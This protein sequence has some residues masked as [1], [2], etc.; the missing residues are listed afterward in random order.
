MQDQRIQRRLATIL[1][2][3]VA[4]YSR[5]M[6]LDEEGTLTRLRSLRKDP[7]D[8]SIHGHSGRIVKT[9]G[10]GFLAEFASPVEAVRCALDVQRKIAESNI[11]LPQ[12]QR[13]EF[14][15]G[16]NLGDVIV[17]DD[18]DLFGDGVNVAARLEAAAEPGSV[19]IAAAVY[20]LVSG[21]P[22][23]P[24]FHDAGKLSLKNIA[25][26]VRA[27]RLSEHDSAAP[28]PRTPA[29]VSS[30]RP[31]IAVLPFTNMSGDAE[32]E[33][34]ADGIT[35][36]IITELSRIGGLLVI[37]RNST[38]TYKGQSPDVKRIARDLSV[39]YVLEGSVRRA[40]NRIRVTA[41]FIEAETGNHIWAEK[42]DRDLADIFDVQDEITRSVVATTQTQVMIHEGAAAERSNSPEL[43]VWGMAKRGWK[44]IY[45]HTRES[46]TAARAM[47]QAIIETDPVSPEGYKLLSAATSHLVFMG[48]ADDPETLKKEALV[49]AQQALRLNERD[50]FSYWAL[51]VALATFFGQHKQAEAAYRRSLEINPNFSLGYGSYGTMLAYDCRPDE[52]IENNEIAIR[53]N[54]RDPSIFFRYSALSIAH[55]LKSDFRQSRDWAQRSVSRKPEWWLGHALLAASLALLDA[56]EPARDSAQELVR[57]LPGVTAD[58]LPIQPVRQPASQGLFHD[59]LRRAGI[60]KSIRHL[61]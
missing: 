9:T 52:A 1:A 16:V 44:E 33:Y 13:I 59:G 17:E 21:Q 36:D 26:P 58:T 12:D 48:F 39:K 32:Q 61:S 60:P 11:N 14:R 22:S 27:Y 2:A 3:D 8:R 18:G 41:Q 4:G 57:L 6:G 30:E 15:I 38:F 55:F 45:S 7:I 49:T 54:P 50:E 37:A 28:L 43:H 56:L 53:L 31:S 19:L 20:D 35:E 23:L 10:D 34:F 5:L 24:Q 51:G 47:G 29:T 40:G 42:Y 25:K 46:L